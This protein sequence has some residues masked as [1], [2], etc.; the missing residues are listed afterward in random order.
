MLMNS[1]IHVLFSVTY[2]AFSGKLLFSTSQGIK[3]NS[4]CF[5]KRL[6]ENVDISFLCGK[7]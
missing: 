4:N 5:L 2:L 1:F 3:V 6:E 7:E